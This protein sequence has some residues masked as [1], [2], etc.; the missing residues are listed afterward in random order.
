M[1]KEMI[2]LLFFLINKKLCSIA[3]DLNHD[4]SLDKD[5]TDTMNDFLNYKNELKENAKD[6]TS[7]RVIIDNRSL[8]PNANELLEEFSQRLNSLDAS[9]INKSKIDPNAN[10][11]P[12]S[13]ADF[14]FDMKTNVT[15]HCPAEFPGKFRL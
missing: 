12:P 8:S 2:I 9:P 13:P 11:P 1:V 10:T 5:L 15:A 7:D 4:N 6:D 14:K 3:G